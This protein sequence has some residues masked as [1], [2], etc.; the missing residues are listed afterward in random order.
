MGRTQTVSEWARELSI[1]KETISSRLRQGWSAE[2]ALGEPVHTEKR[3][4]R[5]TA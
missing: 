1:S 4:R 3:N 2:R 5:H